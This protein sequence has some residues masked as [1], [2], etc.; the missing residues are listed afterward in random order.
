MKTID[1]HAKG[2]HSL[3]HRIHSNVNIREEKCNE[4]FHQISICR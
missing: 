1:L 2:Q 3:G 4:Q